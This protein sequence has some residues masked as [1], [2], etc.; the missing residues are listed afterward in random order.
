MKTL[1]IIKTDGE[2]ITVEFTEDVEDEK[3]NARLYALNI[4]AAL[5][6]QERP[7][8]GEFS[9]RIKPEEV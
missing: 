5:W 4:Q 2:E 7:D 3:V 6:N 1:E 8:E 9:E